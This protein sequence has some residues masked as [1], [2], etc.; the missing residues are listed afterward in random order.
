MQ[1]VRLVIAATALAISCLPAVTASGRGVDPAYRVLP[2]HSA[3]GFSIVKWMV[4]RETGRFTAFSGTIQYDPQRPSSSSVAI[5]VRTAS[6]DTGIAM[7]DSV[8]RSDDFFDVDRFPTMSFRSVAVAADTSSTL[9]VTGDLAIRGVPHRITIPVTVLGTS[10]VHGVGDIA[11]FET[12]FA[13]DRTAF[14]VNGTR[15]S[16]GRLSLSREVEIELRLAAQADQ[17]D[18]R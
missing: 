16:G 14:G 15:W 9:Q 12:R 11:G 10:R 3:V 1:R 17:T 5:D 4:F 7:R 8:L 6:L 2:E 13:I 18:A